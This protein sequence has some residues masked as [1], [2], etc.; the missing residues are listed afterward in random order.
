MDET[1]IQQ[2]LEQRKEIY[3]M[4]Q[5]DRELDASLPTTSHK[6]KPRKEKALFS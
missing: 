5:I 4:E 3:D 2:V 6:D 1:D